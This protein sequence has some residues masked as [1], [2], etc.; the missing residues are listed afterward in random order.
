MG[1]EKEAGIFISLLFVLLPYFLT[2][3][4]LGRTACPI[5]REVSLEEYV[6]VVTASEISWD[7]S[8]EAIKAQ[9]VIARTNLYYRQMEG[10]ESELIQ[11]AA[12]QL[13]KR[14]MND[15]MLRKFEI[16]Q[17]AAKETQGQILKTKHKLVE[18][19]YHALSQGRTRDGKEVLGDDF[20]YIPSVET[21]KD[22]DSPLYV[23]GCYFSIKEL[24]EKI[25]EKYSGFVLGREGIMEIKAVDSAGYV[26]EMQIGDQVFQ[27]E[28]LR[29]LLNLP[30][31][32]FTIQR[33]E[34]EVRFLCRG[35]GHGIGMSQYTAQRMALEGGKYE[36]ILKYFFPE[37]EMYNFS[38]SGKPI[39]GK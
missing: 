20:A 17:E 29:E 28:Q 22:I 21:P 12:G 6:P 30:S 31:S 15:E 18:V 27:G 9:T 2:V 34:E 23:E 24:E 16:F 38:Y 8:K 3:C 39:V 14:E 32:C 19:P 25:K 10:K 5:S 4:T 37:M 26:M 36:E 13:K 35:R 1:N 7:Y 11:E 33:L